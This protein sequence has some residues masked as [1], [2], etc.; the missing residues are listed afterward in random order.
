[1]ERKFSKKDIFLFLIGIM[2]FYF[3]ISLL[4]FNVRSGSYNDVIRE[5]MDK[6]DIRI[7]NKIPFWFCKVSTNSGFLLQTS[8]IDNVRGK[9][10]SY[11]KSQ[12]D[13]MAS[14]NDMI[15]YA[16]SLVNQNATICLEIEEYDYLCL[17]EHSNRFKEPSICYLYYE[18]GISNPDWSFVH[19]IINLIYEGILEEDYCEGLEIR[20]ECYYRLLSNYVL[21]KKGNVKIKPEISSTLCDE[22]RENYSRCDEL[23]E[24]YLEI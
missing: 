7:C 8:L 11:V 10:V 20:D 6:G 17:R 1:M 3:L 22:I 2:F 14:E 24:R 12:L 19:C 21:F 4:V 15:L 16:E 9:C 5:A 18:T 23:Y 13:P